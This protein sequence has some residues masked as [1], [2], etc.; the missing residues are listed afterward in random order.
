MEQIG[1]RRWQKTLRNEVI[2]GRKTGTEV[3]KLWGNEHF[4]DVKILMQNLKALENFLKISL[5]LS[6]YHETQSSF[7]LYYLA[8][9]ITLLDN[10]C[11]FLPPSGAFQIDPTSSAR[12]IFIAQRHRRW[13]VTALRCCLAMKARMRQARRELAQ[14]Y[15][16][17][18]MR[19]PANPTSPTSFSHP[20][21]GRRRHP[22]Q[23][24]GTSPSI[25][26]IK[27]YVT[28]AVCRT[29]HS[30]TVCALW[31]S[32]GLITRWLSFFADAKR[33]TY[34][35]CCNFYF[36]T[37]I[38]QKYGSNF[39]SFNVLPKYTKSKHKQSN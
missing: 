32:W 28:A 15:Y 39:F 6:L 17:T 12:S 34:L 9:W 26:V 1:R 38:I 16:T 25:P 3:I 31:G 8:D 2:N 7:L 23:I 10:R 18:L 19:P 35:T 14:S 24:S 30:R 27:T 22:P 36:F 11:A 29:G 20:L 5:S 21:G 33:E 37:L 4:V 13:H